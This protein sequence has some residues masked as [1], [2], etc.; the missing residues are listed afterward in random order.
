MHTIFFEFFDYLDLQANKLI[1]N[2]AQS[3]KDETWHDQ[4]GAMAPA[5]QVTSRNTAR[6][7]REFLQ[8]PFPKH[9]I[10]KTTWNVIKVM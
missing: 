8:K 6:T 10:A 7:T 9:L 5:D 4:N 1:Q 2:Y 3:L